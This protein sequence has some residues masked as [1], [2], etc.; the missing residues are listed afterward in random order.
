[1]LILRG[2][3]CE[4]IIFED[5]P[6]VISCFLILKASRSL[7]M[8][9]LY[10]F[11][12]NFALIS[13]PIRK[14]EPITPNLTHFEYTNRVP[15][16]LPIHYF[17][18]VLRLLASQLLLVSRTNVTLIKVELFRQAV[19]AVLSALWL[20]ANG[21]RQHGEPLFAIWAFVLVEAP[22]DETGAAEMMIYARV[23]A[24]QVFDVLLV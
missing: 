23:D 8:L 12:W 2:E 6:T 20:H 1:M 22:R 17:Q 13:F 24:C 10:I 7:I 19:F 4:F 15:I 14:G 3:K 16:A 18:K 11:Y 5:K 21:R 9:D